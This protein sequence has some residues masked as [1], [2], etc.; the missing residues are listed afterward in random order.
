MSPKKQWRDSVRSWAHLIELSRNDMKFWFGMR[1]EDS[2]S[3]SYSECR[4]RFYRAKKSLKLSK[5][6]LE[7]A[8]TKYLAKYK[9]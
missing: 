7:I 5:K 6:R 2:R 1:H 9:S 4:Q 3:F 8:T